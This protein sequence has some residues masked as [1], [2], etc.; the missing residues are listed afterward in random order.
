MPWN[1]SRPVFGRHTDPHD[2]F[3][4]VLTR[5]CG[6][7]PG[8]GAVVIYGA[9][10][11]SQERGDLDAVGDAQPQ[12]GVNPEFLVQQVFRLE[13]DPFVLDQQGVEIRDERRVEVQEYGVEI[14]IQF[15]QLVLHHRRGFQLFV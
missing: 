3:F 12:Q 8:F 15:I 11:A 1:R 9:Q 6:L 7:V 13:H 14:L 5:Y 2:H 4:E 10:R